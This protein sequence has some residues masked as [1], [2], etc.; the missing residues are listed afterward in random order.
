MFYISFSQKKLFKI[1]DDEYGVMFV[2]LPERE[3]A[4]IRQ[5]ISARL[6]D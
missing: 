3:L 4:A 6:K 1:V 5:Y 2:N